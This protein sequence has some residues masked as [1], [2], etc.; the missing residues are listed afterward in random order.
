MADIEKCRLSKVG[1]EFEDSNPEV[2]LG[3]RM[4]KVLIYVVLIYCCEIFLFLFLSVYFI[5]L[6]STFLRELKGKPEKE[7][8]PG[9]LLGLEGFI[10]HRFFRLFHPFLFSFFNFLIK[11]I[12]FENWLIFHEVI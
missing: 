7:R 8:V 1:P 12:F 4:D 2:S 9:P 3:R 11:F 5:I 6:I 10:F